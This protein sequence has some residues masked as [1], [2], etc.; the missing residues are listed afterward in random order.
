M[1]AFPLSSSSSP[2][3]TGLNGSVST[4]AQ[5]VVLGKENEKEKQMEKEKEVIDEDKKLRREIKAWWEGVADH[6]DLLVSFVTDD[7]L[8]QT[9]PILALFVLP[10][11]LP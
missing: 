4:S 1:H 10:Y 5:T 3:S 9:L 8:I 7:T 6:L 2:S 11:Y